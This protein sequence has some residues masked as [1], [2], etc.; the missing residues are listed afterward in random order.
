MAATLHK[1]VDERVRDAERRVRDD[2]EVTAREA[3]VGSVR[4]HH[5]DV[6]AE[7]GAQLGGSPRVELHGDDARADLDERPRERA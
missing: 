4:L 1:P 2:V 5:D 3:Q 6:A 7:L